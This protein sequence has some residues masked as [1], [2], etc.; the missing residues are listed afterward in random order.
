MSL[1]RYPTSEK[2]IDR[3][4][5]QTQSASQAFVAMLIEDLPSPP[6]FLLVLRLHSRD[7]KP[8]SSEYI[9]GRKIHLRRFA[10]RASR[11][12]ATGWYPREYAAVS[13]NA[14]SRGERSAFTIYVVTITG[15]FTGIRPRNPHARER[16][17]T[18][19]ENRNHP[20]LRRRGGGLGISSTHGW[21]RCPTPVVDTITSR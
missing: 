10:T 14:F 2:K 1:R 20:F 17:K 19:R 9:E 18:A 16:D 5:R 8:S 13:G 7:E 4:C 15:D 12:R 21:R 3:R 11:L 6:V